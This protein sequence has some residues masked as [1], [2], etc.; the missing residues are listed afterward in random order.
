MDGVDFR[1]L[2]ITGTKKVNLK[3]TQKREA[4][5]GNKFR[6]HIVSPDTDGTT[7]V[8]FEWDQNTFS[9]FAI[10]QWARARPIRKSLS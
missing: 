7:R 10:A 4:E 1:N 8:V 3:E 6:R 2:S 5:N 9:S